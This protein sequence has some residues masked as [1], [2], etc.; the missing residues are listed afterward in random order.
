MVA[1]KF[2]RTR[3]FHDY[4]H[5]KFPNFVNTDCYDH[6]NQLNVKPAHTFKNNARKV[7]FTYPFVIRSLYS[8]ELILKSTTINTF[9]ACLNACFETIRKTIFLNLHIS[10]TIIFMPSLNKR[11][12]VLECYICFEYELFAANEFEE[13]KILFAIFLLTWDIS[14]FIIFDF[15]Y[16]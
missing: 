15:E 5:Q 3:S 6:W 1:L 16:I 4:W 7:C 12:G 10:R 11:W 8:F 2:V 13:F 14:M 9:S